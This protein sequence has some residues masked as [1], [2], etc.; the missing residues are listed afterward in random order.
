[1]P[2]DK[3]DQGAHSFSYALL[4]HTGKRSVLPLLIM[5]G[6]FQEA[7]VINQA[8]T[9]NCPLIVKTIHTKEDI[10][11]SLLHAKYVS[12]SE[13]AGVLIDT[14][15]IAEDSDDLVLRM[16]ECFGGSHTLSLCAS[17]LLNSS[18]YHISSCA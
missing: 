2:D 1:M 12:E 13:T 16:Y 3:A 18:K 10:N 8:A 9:F 4:P 7:G 17:P 15:K 11:L 5:Q 6:S 14:V